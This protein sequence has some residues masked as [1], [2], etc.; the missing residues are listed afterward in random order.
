MA[1]LPKSKKTK[2]KKSEPTFTK[3]AA[4]NNPQKSSTVATKIQK[5]QPSSKPS[6]KTTYAQ[7]E[8]S[9]PNAIKT[10]MVAEEQ[11]HF[12]PVPLPFLKGKDR[13][14][15]SFNA[16]TET[17]MD[18]IQQTI[19]MA[20]CSGQD[21]V[22]TLF[23]SNRSAQD[24]SQSVSSELGKY[25]DQFFSENVSLANAWFKCRTIHD[26]FDFSQQ[27]FASKLGQ[28]LKEYN[29]VTDAMFKV[30]ADQSQQILGSK[31]RSQFSKS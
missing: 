23:S 15:T 30:A 25:F 27:Y 1:P 5:S 14:N 11:K 18:A 13:S 28:Y 26:V 4:L 16:A 3:E 6:K 17:M 2:S 21:R 9:K 19:A 22:D 29:Q 12:L 31:K 24:V 10:R 8:P 20:L 7:K